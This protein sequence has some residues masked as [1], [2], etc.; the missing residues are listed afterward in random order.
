VENHPNADLQG[1]TALTTGSTSGIGRATAVALAARGADVLI[2][3]RNEQRATKVVAATEGQA[4]N[5]RYHLTTL[6]EVAS[7]HELAEWANQA[8][9]GRVDILI[10]N[11]GTAFARPEPIGHRGRLRRDLRRQRQ[12][13][14]L[15]R[16]GTG[17]GHGRSRMG[18]DRQ[19]QHH[20]RQLRSG[21][22][23]HVRR[24]S[25]SF[26]AAIKARAAEYGGRG[27][28]VN[29]VAPGPTRSPMNE[30]FGDMPQ[31]IAALARPRDVKP[32][33]RRSQPRSPTSP[34]MTPA[35]FTV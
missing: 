9:D 11:A 13:A 12:G 22:N 21:R 23:G 28:R 29:A 4:G 25:R 15:S 8:I 14:L 7:A 20:G 32:S 35:S 27:V 30:G 19:C 17:T 26:R 6:A 10:N 3:G 24:K 18:R 33:Q 34:A 16:R 1:K 2:V 31:Q 5:A